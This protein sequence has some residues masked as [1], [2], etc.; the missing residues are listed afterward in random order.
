[1]N[2]LESLKRIPALVE[3]PAS[4][5]RWIIEKGE[6]QDFEKGDY[7]FSRGDPIDKLIIVLKGK[8]SLKI[9][10]NGEF[11]TIAEIEEGEI[12]GALPYSRATHAAGFSIAQQKS[13]IITLDKTFFREMI[14]DYHELTTALVHTMTTRVREFTRTQH[15]QEKLMSLG[16]LS[17]GLAH[18]LNNPASA[19]VRSSTELRKTMDEMPEKLKGIIS[20]ELTGV[21]IDAINKI[22]SDK[23][24][25]S[26][27][28]VKKWSLSRKAEL[29]D[30]MAEWL[31]DHGV[32][33]GYDYAPVLTDYKLEIADI[34]Q[35][36]CNIQNKDIPAVMD[37][38]LNVLTSKSLVD[39]INY[40]SARIS[41]LVSSIKSYTH[42]DRGT[43]MEPLDVTDGI[44]NT[45]KILGHKLKQKQI[46]TELNFPDLIPKI[47]GRTGS[48]NQVWTN[49]IDNAIDAMD[50]EGNLRISIE[51]DADRLMVTIQDDGPGI[52][53]DIQSNIFDP[54]F[55]TKKIGEGT[56]MGLDI[57][58]RIIRNH[59]G[60]IRLQ[61]LP[62]KTKFIFYFPLIDGAK[63]A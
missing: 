31:E 56:G 45:L 12:S 7:L 10:Q 61:S 49:I 62:G 33:D 37:W 35:M 44:N 63:N 54:F 36:T 11:K 50:K 5:L 42:M 38:I 19:M 3:V 8:F 60:E 9:E 22:L 29:E 59:H 16:K 2:Q 23:N 1:M 52:P 43:E 15:Q 53:K 57:V 46:N 6:C 21:Q 39:E 18:E 51:Q 28:E 4:Q 41:D 17:A 14:K 34:E 25:P 27:T 47:S 13:S 58:N 20:A 30:E 32:D 24:K 40:S 26:D 48:L 55:T